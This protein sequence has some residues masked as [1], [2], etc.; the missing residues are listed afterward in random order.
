MAL[1]EDLS[2]LADEAG[3]LADKIQNQDASEE[4]T[5][6]R[7]QRLRRVFG[8]SLFLAE[9]LAQKHGEESMLVVAEKIVTD[10]EPSSLKLI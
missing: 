6:R 9:K 10:L 7:I 1:A 4:E 5:H 8:M 2:T 3:V